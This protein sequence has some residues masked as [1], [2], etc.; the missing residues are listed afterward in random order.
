M[1]SLSQQKTWTWTNLTRRKNKSSHT[2]EA[3]TGVVWAVRR[4]QINLN[5]Y[6][7]CDWRET[8]KHALYRARSKTRLLEWAEMI[9]SWKQFLLNHLCFNWQ[10]RCCYSRKKTESYLSVSGTGNLLHD[11][12]WYVSFAEYGR[13]HRYTGRRWIL[14]DVDAYYMYWEMKVSQQDRPKM[15]LVCHTGILQCTRMLSGLTNAPACFQGSL[16]LIITNHKWKT[17][18]VYI[19]DAII[20]SNNVEYHIKHTDKI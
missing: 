11:G 4:D 6:Q 3:Q 14:H 20:F 1:K 8:F 9:S 10:Q 15:A 19:N 18:L 7:P 17:C 5:A 13:V 2:P 16:H 12:K